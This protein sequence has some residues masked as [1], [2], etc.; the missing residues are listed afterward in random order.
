MSNKINKLSEIV[1]RVE[2]IPKGLRTRVLSKV[3]GT[4]VKFVGTSKLQILEMKR[5]KVHI[6]LPNRKLVQNHIGGVHA[7]AMALLAETATGF[8]VGMAVP[9]DRTP[10]IKSMKVEYQKRT[11]GALEAVATLSEEELERITATPKGEIVV[12]VKVTDES[13]REPIQCEMVWAWVP[14]RRRA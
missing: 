2:Q 12:P 5:G 1:A 10:V 11:K 13:G 9:D 14:K 7:A 8:V 3:L 6:R 4:V